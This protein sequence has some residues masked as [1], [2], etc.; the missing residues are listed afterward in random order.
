VQEAI[1]LS[2]YHEP[3]RKARNPTDRSVSGIGE[4]KAVV[5]GWLNEVVGGGEARK[6]R[7][8]TSGLK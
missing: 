1:E 8:D 4:D 7:R 5:T 2:I 6:V 3:T